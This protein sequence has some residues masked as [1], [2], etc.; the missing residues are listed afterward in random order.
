MTQILFLD[1]THRKGNASILDSNLFF[2]VADSINRGHRLFYFPILSTEI[3]GLE[4]F[5]KSLLHDLFLG[6]IKLE[7]LTR[8]DSFSPARKTSISH[9]PE[10]ENREFGKPP[11]LQ[12]RPCLEMVRV[13]VEQILEQE[14]NP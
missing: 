1:Y 9:T 12:V 7:L 4:N 10:V 14:N 6:Y 8:L 13:L 3:I 5:F 2:L 11:F